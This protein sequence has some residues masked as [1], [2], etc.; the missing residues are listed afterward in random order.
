MKCLGD[1]GDSG[2]DGG[3]VREGRLLLSAERSQRAGA[4][5][6]PGSSPP[7]EQA[8]GAG[9]LLQGKEH[10][11][12]FRKFTDNRLPPC[13]QMFTNPIILFSGNDKKQDQ[14]P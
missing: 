4:P 13:S 2:K 9:E 3:S 8:C 12:T 11:R 10:E 1:R 5:S 6:W 14:L 7:R